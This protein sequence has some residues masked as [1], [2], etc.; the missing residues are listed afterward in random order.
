MLQHM[1][2]LTVLFLLMLPSGTFAAGF[3]QPSN[4]AGVWEMT[5]SEGTHLIS[6][7]VLPQNATLM[8][9]L[10]QQFP[11]GFFWED[12]TRV[13]GVHADTIAGSYFSNLTGEWVGDL[14]D[15]DANKA[16]WLIMPNG[17]PD[18]DLRLIGAA[19]TMAETAIDTLSPGLNFVACPAIVPV[20]LAG[21][22]L[23]ESGCVPAAFAA[24]ADRVY[25]WSNDLLMPA[26]KHPDQGWVGAGFTF[27]PGKGYIIER[28]SG[29][30]DIE[31]TRP[32][33]IVGAEPPRGGEE[34]VVTPDMRLMLQSLE[35]DFS[36]PPW[37]LRNSRAGGQ[38]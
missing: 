36:T 29:D 1:T 25:T 16:Y 19:M 6:F 26:W 17:E 23:I 3:G 24:R 35:F 20:T 27:H 33:L 9:V 14:V 37:E 30:L 18:I 31:W 28:A 34:P 21:S 13:V 12:A 8:S 38:Q 7:P 4:P 11:G 2:V 15:L 10:G 5:V 22:G 32:E